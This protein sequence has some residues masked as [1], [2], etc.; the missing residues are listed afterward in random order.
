LKLKTTYLLFLLFAFCWLQVDAQNRVYNQQTID[1]LREKH[2]YGEKPVKEI[3]EPKEKS[4]NLD[5]LPIFNTVF[6]IVLGVLLL[7]FVLF[8]LIGN[9]SGILFKKEQ[10][11]RDE[12]QF[13]ELCIED[14]PKSELEILLENALAQKNYKVAIRALY[15]L[16]LKHLAETSSIQLKTDKTNYDYFYEIKIDS[17]KQLFKSITNVYDYVWYGEFEAEH[18]HY[19]S[20]MQFYKAIQKK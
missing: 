4:V 13:E 8:L 5:V 9:K 17:K 3:E 15:L 18:S 10:I 2:Q 12:F 20:T 19:Q 16:T 14:T 6:F 11:K 1:D 7:G